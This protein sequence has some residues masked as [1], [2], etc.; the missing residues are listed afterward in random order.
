M[1]NDYAFR[2]FDNSGA[3]L[4]HGNTKLAALQSALRAHPWISAMTWEEFRVAGIR[5]RFD[6][7]QEFRAWQEKQEPAP[8]FE[9]CRS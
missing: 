8:M 7:S 9:P 3:C 6:C 1:W 2:V 5:I 4:G